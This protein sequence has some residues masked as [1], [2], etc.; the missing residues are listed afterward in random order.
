MSFSNR[1]LT[2]RRKAT[3]SRW[4]GSMFAWILKTK[5]LNSASRATSPSP[6]ARP[7]RRGHAQEA[8]QKR[9]DAEVRV[10][11]PKNTASA[12]RAGRAQVELLPRGVQKLDVLWERQVQLSAIAS[13]RRADRRRRAPPAQPSRRRGGALEEVICRLSRSYTPRKSR[14]VRIGQFT[15][16]LRM[17]SVSST[18]VNSR[19]ARARVVEL[20]DEGEDQD[21]ALPGRPRRASSSALKRPSRCR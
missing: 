10:A 17:P 2:T 5:P 16:T 11:E 1:P 21:A 19:A 7:R 20:V 8:L 3:R 18:S 9:H 6:S 4:L 13:S 14:P 15:G 12:R